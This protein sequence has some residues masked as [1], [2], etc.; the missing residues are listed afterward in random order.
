MHS[1]LPTF[2]FC[3]APSD[4]IALAQHR[5]LSPVL[6]TSV[7][8]AAEKEEIDLASWVRVPVPV[9]VPVSRG[10]NS[11]RLAPVG[12]ITSPRI[13]ARARESSGLA[14]RGTPGIRMGDRGNGRWPMA[15]GERGV[16]QPAQSGL[17]APSGIHAAHCRARLDSTRLYIPQGTLLWS[18]ACARAAM[19]RGAPF[20]R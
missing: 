15:D 16:S 18:N 3:T 8:N 2:V 1:I 7:R 10:A 12:A 6:F 4:P 9:P 20:M 11:P 14:G 17:A 19:Q 13:R 5:S